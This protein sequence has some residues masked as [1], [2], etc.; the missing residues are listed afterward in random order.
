[1]VG[2]GF[3]FRWLGFGWFQLVLVSVGFSG[4]NWLLIL[5]VLVGFGCSDWLLIWWF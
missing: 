3:K 1:M 5:V 2:V 4:S